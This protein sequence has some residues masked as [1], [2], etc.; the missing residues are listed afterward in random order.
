VLERGNKECESHVCY[1]DSRWQGGPGMQ[2]KVV[3]KIGMMVRRR[4]DFDMNRAVC[5]VEEMW[6]VP[7]ML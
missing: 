3:G 4:G 6:F 5:E 7:D 2:V 1:F